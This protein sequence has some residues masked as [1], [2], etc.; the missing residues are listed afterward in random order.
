MKNIQ[1]IA[2]RILKLNPKITTKEIANEIY[3]SS[4]ESPS[5][6][7]IIQQVRLAKKGSK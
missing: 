6:N 5:M 3:N 7:K 1:S 4:L 2:K